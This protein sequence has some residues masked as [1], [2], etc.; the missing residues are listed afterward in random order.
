MYGGNLKA[1]PS[2]GQTAIS[3]LRPGASSQA[4][5]T[6]LPVARWKGQCP[7]GPT[8]P[9]PSSSWNSTAERDFSLAGH[10]HE[11][12]CRPQTDH[13]RGRALRPFTFFRSRS[14]LPARGRALA[15]MATTTES[16]PGAR[17]EGPAFQQVCHAASARHPSPS[18]PNNVLPRS[19]CQ[20]RRIYNRLTHDPYKLVA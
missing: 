10:Q 11:P 15:R 2:V 18:R 5:C 4:R 13:H 12:P 3:G 14:P 1:K 9:H 7:L 20:Y 17:H 16:C 8:V 19:T 6:H